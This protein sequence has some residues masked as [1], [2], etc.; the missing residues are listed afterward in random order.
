M[1]NWNVLKCKKKKVATNI[2]TASLVR[3]TAIPN[4]QIFITSNYFLFF[5]KFYFCNKL[6]YK[7][8]LKSEQKKKKMINF[9][10][11]EQL[12][13]DQKTKTEKAE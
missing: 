6:L 1:P 8:I 12:K 10:F 3:T 4:S 9:C 5:S 11:Y 7:Q 2:I 13:F